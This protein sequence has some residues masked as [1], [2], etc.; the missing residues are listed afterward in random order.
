VAYDPVFAGLADATEEG[1]RV[2]DALGTA[3]VLFLA[4]HGVIVVGETIAGCFHGLYLLERAC[5][6]QVLAMSTGRPLAMV[7][8]NAAKAT[9]AD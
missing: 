8:E 3:R 1:E 7:S 4:H 2:G 9:A 5:R 6:H